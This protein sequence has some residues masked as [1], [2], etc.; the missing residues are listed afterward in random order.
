MKNPPNG[1]RTGKITPKPSQQQ[2]KNANKPGTPY[3]GTPSVKT[4]SSREKHRTSSRRETPKGGSTRYLP[5]RKGTPKQTDNHRG[6]E[7]G[8]TGERNKTRADTARERTTGAGD[9]AQSVCTGGAEHRPPKPGIRP[10]QTATP[11]TRHQRAATTEKTD[12]GKPHT[13]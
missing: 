8:I 9:A 2:S 7:P 6:P 12:G 11:K 13:E 3:R 10:G 4:E 1:G 5:P